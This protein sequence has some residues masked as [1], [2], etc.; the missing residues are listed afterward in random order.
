MTRRT[1]QQWLTLFEEQ[2]VSDLNYTEFANSK[3][4]SP[5]YFSLRRS[6]LKPTPCQ[7]SHT[8]NNFVVAKIKPVISFIHVEHKQ[9]SI[10]LPTTIPAIW[11][12]QFIQA[13]G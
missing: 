5:K 6:Q 1:Q 9:S 10:K 7:V 8:E 3:N 4:I 13:L 11:F 2:K 12:A